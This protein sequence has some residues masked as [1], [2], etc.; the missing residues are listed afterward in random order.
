MDEKG[1]AKATTIATTKA[2][3]RSGSLKTTWEEVTYE[4]AVE[5]EHNMLN[6]L[7]Y[8]QS[9][10]LYLTHLLEHPEGDRSPCSW[11]FGIA[12]IRA[13]YSSTTR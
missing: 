4:E 2:G 8:W 10:Y 11:A 1:V 13:V 7:T 12:W 5:E 3:D 6:R 9:K